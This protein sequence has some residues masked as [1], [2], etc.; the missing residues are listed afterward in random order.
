MLKICM[1]AMVDREEADR[2]ALVQQAQQFAQ[3]A[4][5]AEQLAAGESAAAGGQ[6]AGDE[7][8]PGYNELFDANLNEL[9]DEELQEVRN[10]R[11]GFCSCVLHLPWPACFQ[12]GA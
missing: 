10:E 12:T 8:P 1:Q 7:V 2:A 9:S 3:P 11:F 5:A 4:A 6:P